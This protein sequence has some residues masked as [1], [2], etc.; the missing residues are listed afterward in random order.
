MFVFLP[1]GLHVFL[2]RLHL[3]RPPRLYAGGVG[4]QREAA[5]G[6]LR[7]EE[8]KSAG[9]EGESRD[10]ALILLFF[11]VFF[12]TRQNIQN[13]LLFTMLAWQVHE[14]PGNI[15]IPLNNNAQI[16]QVAVKHLQISIKV[17]FR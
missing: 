9:Q 8:E 12:F 3:F 15:K 2:E 1:P 4:P 14:T 5:A 17:A 16:K 13:K 10:G 11:C 7:G 6:A